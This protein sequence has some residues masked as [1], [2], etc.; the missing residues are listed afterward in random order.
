MITAN[1]SAGTGGVDA[2]LLYE[3]DRPENKGAEAFNQTY[4]FLTSQFSRKVSMAD[5]TALGV[6]V[7]V[8]FCG[9]PT[10]QVR[11]GRIDATGPGPSGVPEPTD[12]TQK[13]VARFAT[14]G[15]N[16]TEMV[17]S[18]RSPYFKFR[19]YSNICFIADIRWHAV[20]LSVSHYCKDAVLVN[21]R[22]FFF[23]FAQVPSVDATS[24]RLP[25]V[26]KM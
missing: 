24:L 6:Y 10:L 2:S 3:M 9:G 7:T 21:L 12:A 23:F 11:A 18:V 20:T 25:V 14:A 13:M 1:V 4:G 8:T 22:K 19:S 5:L 15:F 16:V 26:V 17:A